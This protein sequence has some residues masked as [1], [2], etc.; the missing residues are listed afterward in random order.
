MFFFSG[1]FG[2]FFFFFFFFFL[3]VPSSMRNGWY[4]GFI[5]RRVRGGV[6]V[7]GGEVEVIHR[8][9]QEFRRFSLGT[10]GP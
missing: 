10:Y 6:K 2:V 8:F 7:Q 5:V 1:G 4:V 3:W 9:P